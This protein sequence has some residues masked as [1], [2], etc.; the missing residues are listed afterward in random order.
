MSVIRS[1]RDRQN[2]YVQINKKALEDPKIS[3]KAKGFIAY[4]LS[5]KDDWIF[6]VDQLCKVLKEKEVSI[7][8]II[9]EC[10]DH[11]YAIRWRKRD[12]LGKFE[13]WQTIISDS[14]EEIRRLRDELNSDP[15][16]QKSYAIGL[17]KV[18]PHRGFPD[19]DSPHVENQGL[20]IK[21]SSNNDLSKI[22]IE[23]EKSPPPEPE[24][25]PPK[26]KEE[27]AGGNNNFYKCLED[28]EDMSLRQKR[29]FNKYPQEV[30]DQAARYCYHSSVKL[31]GP[32]ARIK[33]MHHF[34]QNPLDYQETM[35]N[36]DKPKH[37]KLSE[38]QR[39]LDYF[40]HGEK[41]NGYECCIDKTNT[42]ICFIHPMR[43]HSYGIMWN[44]TNFKEEFELILKRLEL[45][46]TDLV[47]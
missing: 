27:P 12:K 25:T 24:P 16:I 15:E 38:K 42:G 9:K 11:D 31:E 39:I 7:Y 3:L 32:G 17:K 47:Q 23:P 13:A 6:Y 45:K 28:K 33:Q 8:N 19:L 36:L 40:K 35:K 14:Q 26:P 29:Q 18:L 2:P 10:I 41:Y 30:I 46:W 4:C 34:C 37:K 44:D 5:K 1:V 22:I 43:V 20:I 21:D